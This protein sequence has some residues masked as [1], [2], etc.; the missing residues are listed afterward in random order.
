M[1]R[2]LITFRPD[3][4]IQGEVGSARKRSKWRRPCTERERY[5]LLHSKEGSIG[6]LCGTLEIDRLAERGRIETN[7]DVRHEI[8]REVEE[9]IKRRALLIPLYH[10]DKPSR[11]GPQ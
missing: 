1:G 6:A 4:R 3:R 11:R 9:I 7:P 10:G 8:Y 5:R 2:G